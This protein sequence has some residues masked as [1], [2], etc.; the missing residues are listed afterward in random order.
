[1]AGCTR[2]HRHAMCWGSCWGD[3]RA[4]NVRLALVFRLDPFS[5]RM[6]VGPQR[7]RGYVRTA[8]GYLGMFA[9]APRSR[10]IRGCQLHHRGL[11]VH[12]VNLVCKP[13]SDDRPMLVGYFRRD[14]ACRRSSIHRGATRGSVG[15]DLV[16]SL[17]YPKPSRTCGPSSFTSPS[18]NGARIRFS[19][20]PRDYTQY[21]PLRVK[22]SLP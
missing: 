10:A 16:V 20:V 6:V 4:P 13:G 3:H 15:R 5:T 8:V 2:L 17:A 11:L 21:P 18:L 1:L 9:T 14:S 22:Q 12:G 7:V 19:T